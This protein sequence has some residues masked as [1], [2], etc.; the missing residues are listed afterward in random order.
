MSP[1]RLSLAILLA[2]AAY[3]VVM[4]IA[5]FLGWAVAHA[6]TGAAAPDNLTSFLAKHGWWGGALLAYG[7]VAWLLK[8]NETEHW[9]A[10]GRTLALIT[11]ALSVVGSIIGWQMGLDPD[12]ILFAVSSAVPLVVS[13]TVKPVLPP[14]TPSSPVA[15]VE[16]ETPPP[17]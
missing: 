16:G 3:G 12:A 4:L 6:D 10:K 5:M 7:V 13:P 8:R 9:I 11:A 15:V 1:I 14:P 2:P 17:Q